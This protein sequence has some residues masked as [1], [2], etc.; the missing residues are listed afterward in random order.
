MTR[1][2]LDTPP[3][4]PEAEDALIPPHRC[5]YGDPWVDI[6]LELTGFP[7]APEV[8]GQL[9]HETEQLRDAGQADLSFF[10]HKPPGLRWRLQAA[11][12]THLPELRRAATAAAAR[13]VTP[14]RVRTAVYEPQAALFGGTRSMRF[15]HRTWSADSAL[16]MR[17]HARQTPPSATERWDLSFGVLS[18]VFVALGVVGW[19]DREVWDCV[20]E[21]T[22]RRL[23][24]KE[25]TRPQVLAAARSL[26]S[27]WDAVWGTSRQQPF[28]G[29]GAAE[30]ILHEF[31]L[32][33]APTLADWYDL[34][35]RPSTRHPL[36]PR[37]A[38]AYWTVFH[39]N[40]AGLTAAQ[41]ALTAETLAGM[42]LG[43]AA[44]G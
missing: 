2:S 26:S 18:R 23:A 24:A 22:G 4:L 3:A 14:D 11:D 8:Y 31:S 37:R 12:G 34:L 25:W 9:L 44:G 16:W 10:I 5:G 32:R 28:A 1:R 27:R 13:I 40:R 43:P 20:S 29:S 17:W 15:V 42:P 7:P 36:T 19:E 21:D 38:A 41:Q 6:G 35:S 39:W 33:A 30:R